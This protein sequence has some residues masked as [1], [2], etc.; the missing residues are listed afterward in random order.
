[1]PE[2]SRPRNLKAPA[3]PLSA[4]ERRARMRYRRMLLAD[5]QRQAMASSVVTRVSLKALPSP[6]QLHI[7]VTD[8]DDWYAFCAD[9]L[10]A[11]QVQWW[12]QGDREAR[13]NNND[14]SVPHFK[15]LAAF[16][17]ALLQVGEQYWETTCAPRNKAGRPNVF[18]R[19]W[20]AYQKELKA[21][22]ANRSCT[23]RDEDLFPLINRRPITQAAV[24]RMIR[25]GDQ[26]TPKLSEEVY[27]KYARLLHLSIKHNV[28][29][30]ESLPLRDRTFIKKYLPSLPT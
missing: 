30:L 26:D 13:Y 22:L 29:S 16:R 11:G 20:R 6:K 25:K 4:K 1:M 9:L 10:A 18:F 3:K 19:C 8:T 27:R 14:P 28:Q 5:L 15:T 2:Q 23:L 7:Y 21:A 12:I 24:Q 17:K